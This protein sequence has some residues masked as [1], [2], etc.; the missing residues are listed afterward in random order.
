MGFNEMESLSGCPMGNRHAWA[1]QMIKYLHH[2]NLKLVDFKLNGFQK[3]NPFQ[4]KLV[5]QNWQEARIVLRIP[6]VNSEFLLHS[7]YSF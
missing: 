4:E 5:E 3:D 1:I 7:S 6:T 2:L